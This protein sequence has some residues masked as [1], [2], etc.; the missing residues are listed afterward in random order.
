MAETDDEVRYTITN[1]GIATVQFV[2]EQEGHKLN[3]DCPSCRDTLNWF[4]GYD[5]RG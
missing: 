4:L 5:P 3:P 2:E 1:K